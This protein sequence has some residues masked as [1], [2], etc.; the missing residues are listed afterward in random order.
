L[1]VFAKDNYLLENSIESIGKLG[2]P[3]KEFIKVAG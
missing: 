1:F 3:R 2:K